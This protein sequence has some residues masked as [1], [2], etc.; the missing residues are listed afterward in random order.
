MLLIDEVLCWFLGS[1]RLDHSV[2]IMPEYVITHLLI[3]S[4]QQ[5]DVYLFSFLFHLF[6]LHRAYLVGDWSEHL[7]DITNFFFVGC[8]LLFHLFVLIYLTLKNLILLLCFIVE[9][10][11]FDEFVGLL[12]LLL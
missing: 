1:H 7:I 9:G 2:D 6:L 12:K 10:F 4:L 11:K 8:E 5:V 3:D